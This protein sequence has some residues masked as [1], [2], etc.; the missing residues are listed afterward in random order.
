M[1]LASSMRSYGAKG[2]SCLALHARELQDTPTELLD[3]PGLIHSSPLRFRNTLANDF[4]T[5][6]W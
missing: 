2:N 5:L 4:C 1:K 3:H 6:G